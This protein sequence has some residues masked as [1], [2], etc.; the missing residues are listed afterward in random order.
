MRISKYSWAPLLLLSLLL[1]GVAADEDPYEPNDS[2][3]TATPILAGGGLVQ[4]H[5]F[6]SADDVDWLRLWVEQDRLYQIEIPDDS[7]AADADPVIELIDDNGENLLFNPV[8]NGYAGQGEILGWT[9]EHQGFVYI[10]ISRDSGPL[11]G[12]KDGRYGV[13]VILP[14]APQTGYLQG[15]V[16]SAC[17]QTP[18]PWAQITTDPAA[19]VLSQPDG[20][21]GLP[22]FPG[23]Y[24]VSVAASGFQAGG[25]AVSI[26]EN[27]ATTL[28]FALTPLAGCTL[29]A[30]RPEGL[31]ASDGDYADRVRVVWSDVA[32]V[33]AYEVYRCTSSSSGSCTRA[34]TTSA[35]GYDDAAVQPGSTYYFRAKACQSGNCSE[36][37]DQDSGYAKEA[38]V[39]LPAAPATIQADAGA[40]RDRIGVGWSAVSGLG[41]YSLYRCTSPSQGACTLIAET[42]GTAHTDSPLPPGAQYYYR[43]RGCNGASCSELSAAALGYTAAEPACVQGVAQIQSLSLSDVRD[44]CATE[45]IEIGPAVTLRPGAQVVARAPWIRLLPPVNILA[46]AAFRAT[47]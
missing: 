40:Y 31:A 28:D 11:S 16:D 46:G 1:Q 24:Q 47:P 34:A 44:Y 36:F 3:E 33:E 10:L 23:D 13:R 4:Q 8:N 21:Y 25:G 20:S 19:D 38:A 18:I 42:T 37:S 35:L 27:Q 2:R 43:A 32:N 12:G 22:L 9:A 5:R 39:G 6:R 41:L 45:G 15:A 7:V 17:D 30:A 26:V 29:V 14:L